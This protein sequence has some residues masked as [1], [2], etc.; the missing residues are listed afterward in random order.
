MCKVSVLMSVYHEKEEYLRRS[1]ESILNQTFEDF[2]FLIYD[3][4]TSM[5]NKVILQEYARN[6]SR[7]RIIENPENRGLTYNL[8]RGVKEARGDYIA[9]MDSDDIS[10]EFRL[11][12]QVKYMDCHPDVALLTTSVDWIGGKR[13]LVRRWITSG[14]YLKA[15]LLFNN[16]FP[17]PTAMMRRKYLEQYELNYDIQMKKAQDYDFW[18]R[19]A[20]KG[21]I[22]FLRTSCVKYRIHEEQIS[23]RNSKEQNC[24]ANQIRIRQLQNMGIILSTEDEQIYLT[25]CDGRLGMKVLSCW[26]RIKRIKKEILMSGNYNNFW[27]NYLFWFRFIRNCIC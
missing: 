12:K 15:T 16:S 27:I 19:I 10:K 22:A 1:I 24:F 2:E 21:K 25:F 9:R 26:K 11:K 18:V 6:D 4:A 17:H 23:Q 14:D 13:N 7:I 20:E 5:D 8:I 3:D